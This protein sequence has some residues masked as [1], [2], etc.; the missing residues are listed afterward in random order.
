MP[1]KKTAAITKKRFPKQLTP[2]SSFRR[3]SSTSGQ[4]S[5]MKKQIKTDQLQ[6][7]AKSNEPRFGNID[8]RRPKLNFKSPQQAYEEAMNFDAALLNVG[9]RGTPKS[10][11]GAEK[12]Y[13]LESKFSRL[14]KSI[15]NSEKLY[16]A[17]V[18][19]VSAVSLLIVTFQ[20]SISVLVKCIVI[21]LYLTILVVTVITFKNR[22]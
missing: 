20:K 9:V 12:Y 7:V 19:V 22:T 8:S 14:V 3:I 16:P 17:I 2:A 11:L 15:N 1:F 10:V 13:S 18:L 21:L 4:K 5:V 6:F